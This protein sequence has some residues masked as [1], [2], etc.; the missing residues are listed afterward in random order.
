MYKTDI[1]MFILVNANAENYLKVMRNPDLSASLNVY[2]LDLV[3]MNLL[4]K[5]LGI[6]VAHIRSLFIFYTQKDLY[7]GL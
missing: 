4:N 2:T 7:L 1:M 6:L 5:P 3:E